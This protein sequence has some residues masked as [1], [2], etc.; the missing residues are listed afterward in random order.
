[1]HRIGTTSSRQLELYFLM[2]FF[3]F[4]NSNPL[5]L[6]I[7]FPFK[8]NFQPVLIRTPKYSYFEKRRS[9][10]IVT[11]F[12]KLSIIKVRH[13]EN[14]MICKYDFCIHIIYYKIEFI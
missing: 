8:C 1:M 14:I 4:F 13:C 12:K 3:F 9:C 7:S 6:K 5:Q 11:R 2:D 10:K